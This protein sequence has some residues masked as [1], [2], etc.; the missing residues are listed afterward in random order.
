MLLMVEAT[1]LSLN[2]T[3]YTSSLLYLMTLMAIWTVLSLTRVSFTI[4]T[5]VFF[6]PSALCLLSWKYL[7]MEM[8]WPSMCS[9]RRG[10]SSITFSSRF[11]LR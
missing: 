3:K 5:F 4:F 6:Y 9:L 11:K 7:L 1:S 10:D 2:L 8:V